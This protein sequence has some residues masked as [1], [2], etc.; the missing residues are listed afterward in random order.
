MG[1]GHLV[2]AWFGV[3]GQ[4]PGAGPGRYGESPPVLKQN[5]G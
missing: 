1:S 4:Q 2:L 5:E 3:A